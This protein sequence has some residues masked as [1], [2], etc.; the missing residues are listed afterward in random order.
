MKPFV[1]QRCGIELDDVRC[2]P[3]TKYCKLCLAVKE[4]VKQQKKYDASHRQTVVHE[5]CLMCGK[6][7][8]DPLTGRRRPKFCCYKCSLQYN[9]LAVRKPKQKVKLRKCKICT[10][11]FKPIKNQVYC[12]TY[13]HAEALTAY[14][15]NRRKQQKL[16]MVAAR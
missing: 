15:R 9:W 4:R 6:S 14:W 3:N 1:C 10:K 16:M 7:L 5:Q 12:S 2:H 11:I 8:T 13:C